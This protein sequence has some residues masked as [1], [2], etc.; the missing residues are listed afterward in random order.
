MPLA[1]VM[2]QL[3]VRTKKILN[4]P[5]SILFGLVTYYDNNDKQFNYQYIIE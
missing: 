5:I 1:E 4:L 2:L 3:A